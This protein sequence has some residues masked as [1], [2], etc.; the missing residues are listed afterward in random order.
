MEVFLDFYFS[1]TCPTCHVPDPHNFHVFQNVPIGYHKSMFQNRGQIWRNYLFSS[2]SV[3]NHQ[4]TLESSVPFKWTWLDR[5]F[6]MESIS[7]HNHQ[8]CKLADVIVLVDIMFNS[9]NISSREIRYVLFL[10]SLFYTISLD[11]TANPPSNASSPKHPI[12]ALFP[13]TVNTTLQWI[14]NMAPIFTVLW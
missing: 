4:N 1:I 9:I 3:S 14:F 5:A 13:P 12:R 8:D 2:V 11:V 6:N 7:I 10:S